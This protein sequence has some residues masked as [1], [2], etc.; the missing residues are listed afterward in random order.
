MLMAIMEAKVIYNLLV[1]RGKKLHVVHYQP[2]DRGY[3]MGRPLKASH[4]PQTS[5]G[6]KNRTFYDRIIA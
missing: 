3:I 6:Q 1:Q 2:C 4:L 5:D